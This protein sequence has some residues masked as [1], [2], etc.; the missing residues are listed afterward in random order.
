MNLGSE[1]QR[2]LSE[3]LPINPV[4]DYY[5]SDSE[6]RDEMLRVYQANEERGRERGPG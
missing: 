5:E 3:P 1:R 2:E 4:D 6:D